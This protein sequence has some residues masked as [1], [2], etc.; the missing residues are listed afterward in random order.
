MVIKKGQN[1]FMQIDKKNASQI[2]PR[3]ENN[4]NEKIKHAIK[5]LL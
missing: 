4:K 3:K 5:D 1:K 2:E